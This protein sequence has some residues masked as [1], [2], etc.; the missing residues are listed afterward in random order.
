MFPCLF[1]LEVVK[2]CSVS[3]RLTGG[4]SWLW[5]HELDTA[6]EVQEL[7]LIS[8]MLSS[9]ALGV[10]RDKWKWMDDATGIF[11]VKSAKDILVRGRCDPNAFVFDR[12]K[13]VP[14]KCN[15]FAWRLELNRTP[16]YDALF[17]RGI[18][19]Q[20]GACLLCGCED[21]SVIHLFMSC[22]FADLIW[23]KVSRWC[24]IPT[25][26]GF[27]IKDLLEI[28][29]FSRL[30]SSESKILQGIIIIA[31]WCIWLVRNKVVFSGSRANVEDVFSELRSMGYFWLKHR[32]A[33]QSKFVIV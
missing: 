5:K 8:G 27:S 10:G 3:D 2:N 31:C 23:Q 30:G 1:R 7:A 14:V 24:R 29:K 9:F 17:S 20:V 33:F 25:I 22:R 26:F 21:E 6:S 32:S 18:V 16:T 11:S 12:C 4:D 28:H 13:W 15:I 19:N